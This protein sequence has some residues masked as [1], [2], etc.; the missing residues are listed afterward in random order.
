MTALEFRLSLVHLVEQA[1][2][3]KEP[4]RHP[5][6]WIKATFEKNAGPLVTEREIE[7]RFLHPTVKS[8]VKQNRNLETEM[9]QELNLMRRYLT[10]AP[11]D[12]STIDEIA[13]RMAAPLL[14]IVADDKKSG[15]L[16]EA[17]ISALK[18]FFSKKR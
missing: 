11:E 18:E 6:A 14:K 10:C 15:M 7:N 17:R 13:Q 12:R 2:T 1:K 9:S 3:G 4:V 8:E 5:N 16:E